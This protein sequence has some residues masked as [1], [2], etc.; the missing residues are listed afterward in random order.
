MFPA[1]GLPAGSLAGETPGFN[2]VVASDA[3]SYIIS[4]VRNIA[5]FQSPRHVHVMKYDSLGTPL[6]GVNHVAVYDASSVPIAHLPRLASDGAG[7]AVL[8]WHSSPTTTFNAR[9]QRIDA[10]GAELFAHNGVTVSTDTTRQH[11]DPTMLY[12]ASSQEIFVFFSER[13]AGQSQF[14]IYGQKFDAS[15][16]RQWGASAM[17]FM[18]VDASFNGPS[19]GVLSGTGAMLFVAE[20]I[21]GAAGPEELLGL[22]VDGA[23]AAQ[24]VG[25][26]IV[27]SNAASGKADQQVALTPDGGALVVW[28]DNRTDI[29]DV[30][31]QRINEDGTLG[32]GVVVIV[33]PFV[34]GDCSADGQYNIADA[35]VGLSALFP[36]PGGA[37]ALTCDDAC[38]CNDDGAFN[39]ADPICILAGLFGSPTTPP[40][41]PHPACGV[42]PTDTDPLDCATFAPCP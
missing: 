30:Y 1:A 37:P 20:Q 13:N 10:S 4:W 15:G 34:R 33:D 28:Q 5:T 35:I 31:A 9:V 8:A 27:L 19:E 3:G 16:T 39:V 6:W 11:L 24:W 22:R 25:Q 41:A 7:G 21:G 42:D 17:P 40:V 26:P 32:P 36:G 12:N 38:D 29:S 2:D 23:G 14:G 18:P